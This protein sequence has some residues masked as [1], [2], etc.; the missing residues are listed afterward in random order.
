MKQLAVISGK[1]GTGKTS[2]TAAF[3]ALSPEAV[4]ADCD[5]DAANLHLLICDGLDLTRSEPF[6]SGVKAGVNPE[7][8]TGCG[9]C[10]TACRFF[11]IS[12]VEDEKCGGMPLAVV[13][14]MSCE[15]CG[16]CFDGCP[17]G[18][19]SLTDNRAGDLFVSP[20]RFGTLVHAGLNPG[21]GSSGKLVTKVRTLAE[22]LAEENCADLVVI[23]GSPGVGCPV[24][25]SLSGVDAV[26][27]VTEPTV[28]GRSDLKRVL[29]LC[30]HFD[31]RAH[32]LINKYDLSEDMALQIQDECRSRE[33]PVLGMLRFD[34]VFVSAMIAGK[35]IIEFDDGPTAREV[36]RL[37]SSLRSSL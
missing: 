18:A 17:H 1:G 6:V 16:V 15:G 28:S 24:I 26:L 32:V 30:G 12:M 27:I 33:I 25:A 9:W 34:P 14:G 10:E 29:E 2:L 22:S 35:T 31:L 23:D 4:F 21:E 36:R 11:A 19:V 8:C 5:V 13:D 20:S 37:W 7:I 3:A